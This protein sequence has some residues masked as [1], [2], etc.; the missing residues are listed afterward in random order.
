MWVDYLV[1]L[2]EVLTDKKLD[3]VDGER[4]QSE[5]L[6]RRMEGESKDVWFIGHQQGIALG[7][8]MH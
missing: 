7:L 4:I 6:Q 2:F 1:L 8:S 3:R 5:E